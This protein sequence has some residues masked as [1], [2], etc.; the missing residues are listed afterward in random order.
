MAK[1]SRKVST[2]HPHRS[3][4][5]S[6]KIMK[7]RKRQS[8]RKQTLNK[9]K[10]RSKSVRKRKKTKK[11]VGGGGT[12]IAQVIKQFNESTQNKSQLITIDEPH[13]STNIVDPSVLQIKV[14]RK[15]KE[16]IS[17]L[18]HKQ[19][20]YGTQ[21]LFELLFYSKKKDGNIK[22]FGIYDISMVYDGSPI[23][24]PP[25]NEYES[26]DLIKDPESN[27]ELTTDLIIKQIDIFIKD[28]VLV[29]STLMKT[30]KENQ[31]TLTQPEQNILDIITGKIPVPV[32]VQA[33]PAPQVPPPAPQVPTPVKTLPNYRIALDPK[34]YDTYVLDIISPDDEDS[35]DRLYIKT[36]YIEAS[37]KYYI[38][39]GDDPAKINQTFN[40]IEA[41][42]LYYKTNNFNY[43]I[44]GEHKTFKL[45]N[46]DK[47]KYSY[48]NNILTLYNKNNN[49]RV[50]NIEIKKCT[51]SGTKIFLDADHE[52]FDS[53]DKLIAYYKENSVLYD[54]DGEGNGVN[55]SLDAS[56]KENNDFDFNLVESSP[57]ENSS[58]YSG[59]GEVN[60]Y[61]ELH[62]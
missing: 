55:I 5:S 37:Y 45:N 50:L 59:V 12:K 3:K 43:T 32:R 17:V 19:I 13:K 26:S 62:M 30:Q 46:E 20:Y 39:D 15:N 61:D 53:I 4:S 23:A 9:R 48:S 22:A 24:D 21:P 58:V 49:R 16:W 47:Y 41:L 52:K 28:K 14:R 33:P 29:Y 10:S 27:T 1:R 42:I 7:R 51:G 8:S 6:R 56:M 57:C 25:N 36:T 31:R 60:V 40:S 2:K 44:G 11:I 18:T 34:Q 54:S 38:A 35:T